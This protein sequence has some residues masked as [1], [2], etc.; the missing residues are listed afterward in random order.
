[1]AQTPSDGL[2]VPDEAPA[3]GATTAPEGFV[4]G[5]LTETGG[6]APELGTV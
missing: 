3:E 5:A 2:V 1:M 4:T 6:C